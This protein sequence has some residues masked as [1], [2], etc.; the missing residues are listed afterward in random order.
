MEKNLINR[1]DFA[2]WQACDGMRPEAAS[3]IPLPVKVVAALTRVWAIIEYR[4]LLADRLL[5]CR[6]YSWC[7]PEEK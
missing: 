4:D 3:K 2:V 5:K 1:K 7:E 6:G